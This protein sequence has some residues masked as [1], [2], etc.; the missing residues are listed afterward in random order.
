VPTELRHSHCRNINLAVG[1]LSSWCCLLFTSLDCSRSSHFCL[2]KCSPDRSDQKMWHWVL[3]LE[4]RQVYCADETLNA[5]QYRSIYNIY[6][7]SNTSPKVKLIW[8]TV[9]N[10]MIIACDVIVLRLR[11]SYRTV[12]VCIS[13]QSRHHVWRVACLWYCVSNHLLSGTI[14]RRPL[15]TCVYTIVSW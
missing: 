1:G 15:L 3:G 9:H 4:I 8:L 10:A 11:V 7:G 13:H 12:Q 6:S 2:I 14:P 5:L